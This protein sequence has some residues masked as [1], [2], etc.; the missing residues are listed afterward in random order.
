MDISIW[1][2]PAFSSESYQETA[3]NV[4]C[5]QR[6]YVCSEDC[7][8]VYQC[9]DGS[10]DFQEIILER[11][12]T[13]NGYFCSSVLGKCSGTFSST[14]P[15]AGYSF[16][17]T[18]LGIFPDPYDC[19][20]YHLC[21]GSSSDIQHSYQTCENGWL[22][23][24]AYNTCIIEAEKCLEDPVPTCKESGQAGPINNNPVIYYVC[25]ETTD[26]GYLYPV[27]FACPHGGRARALELS[28]TDFPM[29]VACEMIRG[30]H[31]EL[32]EGIV[33]E[34][35]D[36]DFPMF[37][38][39]EM[40]RGWHGELREG[41]VWELSDTDFPMF[42]ECEMIRGW[43]G[44]L[45]EGIVWELG[46]TDFPMFVEC[47]MIRGW[48][49]ELREGIAQLANALVVLSSTAED[50]EIAVVCRQETLGIS[51][52]LSYL[53]EKTA[54]K[55]ASPYATNNCEERGYYCSTDCKTVY[56][57][58]GDAPD[59]VQITREVCDTNRGYYCSSAQGTC[60]T[61]FS[62]TCTPRGYKFVCTTIGTFPDPFDCARYHICFGNL[63]D[64]QHSAED[65]DSG[66]LYDPSAYTCKTKASYCSVD[67]VPLCESDGQIGATPRNPSIYYICNTGNSSNGVYLYPVLYLCPHGGIFDETEDSCVDSITP[68]PSDVTTLSTDAPITNPGTNAT[69]KEVTTVLPATVT[70]PDGTPSCTEAGPLSDPSDCFSYYICAED[71]SVSHA[72]CDDGYHYSQSYLTCVFG[73]CPDVPP[74]SKPTTDTPVTHTKNPDTEA[75]TDSDSSTV[76]T[77]RTT[78]STQGT[79][80][81]CTDAG[82]IMDP[83]D[84]YSYYICA[85]DLS[86][87][88]QNCPSGFHYSSSYLACV[89][90]TCPDVPPSSNT[91]TT[92][93]APSTGSTNSDTSAPDDGSVTTRSTT[94]TTQ[95]TVPECTDA[96]NIMDPNDCYSYYICAED[97]SRTH[98]NCPS[99][100]HYSSSYLACVFGTCPDV[101]PSSNT[102]TTTSAPSTGS[103]NSDTSAPDD[104]S[105]T[106]R[107]TTTTTQGTVPTCTSAGNIADPD[108]CYSYYECAEDLSVTH[109]TC[110]N[111]YHYS[112]SFLNCIFGACTVV[113]FADIPVEK[114]DVSKFAF[115][116]NPLIN[117]IIS[118]S[119]PKISASIEYNRGDVKFPTCTSAGNIE[120]ASDCYSYYT[121]DSDLNILHKTCGEGYHFSDS[122]SRCVFGACSNVP[123]TSGPDTTAP[124]P[125]TSEPDDTS[126]ATARPTTPTQ[127]TTCV[128]TGNVIDVN[129]CYSYYLCKDDLSITHV[130][131]DN[132]YHFSTAY[133]SCVFGTCSD[134]PHTSK[135]VTVSPNPSTDTDPPSGD[136][137]TT[138]GSIPACISSGSIPDPS[139]CY[140]YYVCGDD[141]RI[142]HERC[143]DGYHFSTSFLSCVFGSCEL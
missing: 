39:C 29:S 11:C 20:A 44:E 3:S 24:P 50:G 35:S 23:D 49:G 31:G 139:D 17:C 109:Q 92:T 21:F 98:Q 59:F 70:T 104:G 32:R 10:P 40:I 26:G 67:P 108:D 4:T 78:T 18:S 75:P 95:G 102:T 121:C 97:L 124:S 135:P 117:V 66:W 41:I 100:F 89:F 99:G 72:T 101:P 85:E 122:Y 19:A 136:R 6:G 83:N 27:L 87:T 57:C 8:T 91:T 9:L 81:E 126:T 90:G 74:T 93:S 64:I 143:S 61:T 71:L 2:S 48:H 131:C 105:V 63:S 127:G 45:R 114:G 119:L 107:S 116:S 132:G 13:G 112:A 142:T 82:N 51:R 30:W 130:S 5:A 1:R 77:Q 28:D 56:Q 25:E 69:T 53:D 140:S 22:Y 134:I 123:S 133:L 111:G 128:S 86:I 60:S 96:G 137:T 52:P 58:S 37:V 47:E 138:P 42:V 80:P 16:S 103:T 36:T 129:D 76:T 106:T 79:V 7:R 62:N 38:A 141:L 113:L 43:H 120:D 115:K 110:A 84:C 54:R 34:L 46:D 118:N 65:C 15:P 125:D 73:T 68:T 88:H 55:E 14:C 94:T 12:D 33:W